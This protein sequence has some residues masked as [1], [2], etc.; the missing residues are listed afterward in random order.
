MDILWRRQVDL[1]TILKTLPAG[2]WTE[3]LGVF[4]RGSYA[5]LPHRNPYTFLSL[6]PGTPR[7]GN[8]GDSENI[9]HA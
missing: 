2:S 7:G 8:G 9:Q 1:F 6:C 4:V 3:I 5:F